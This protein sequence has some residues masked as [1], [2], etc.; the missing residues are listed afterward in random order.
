L[1]TIVTETTEY[2]EVPI[3]IYQKLSN[4]RILFINDDLSDKLASDLCATLLLKDSESSTEK[5]TLFIN[6]EHG[7]PRNAFMVY[8]VMRMVECPIETICIG[9][10]MDECA[11]ILAAGSPGMRF[12]TQN[13]AIAIGPLV[14]N[15]VGYSNIANAKQALDQAVRDNKKMMEAFARHSGKTLQDTLSFFDKRVFLTPTAAVKRGII[16]KVITP[17]KKEKNV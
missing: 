5:I 4:D 9:S 1:N 15:H 2:G 13:S 11:I 6:A 14:S 17:K 7:D 12:A 10:A 8:D 16:D 3:D